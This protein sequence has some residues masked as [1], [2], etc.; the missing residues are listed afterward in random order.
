MPEL[1]ASWLG[2]DLGSYQ[3]TIDSLHLY[4]HDVPKAQRVQAA[5]GPGPQMAGLATAWETL[6]D[7]LASVITGIPLPGQGLAEWRACSAS[8]RARKAGDPD[9]ADAIAASHD[10]PLAIALRRWYQH[11]DQRHR[12]AGESG[13]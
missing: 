5:A 10:G 9:A 13:R 3:L 8:Y 1:L 12:L 6:D 4:A 2:A 11:I 7:V